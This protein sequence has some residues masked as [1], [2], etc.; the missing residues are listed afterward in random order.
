MEE[1]ALNEMYLLITRVVI[2]VN[3]FG[4]MAMH[5]PYKSDDILC[6]NTF[7]VKKVW[8]SK[9]EPCLEVKAWTYW[10]QQDLWLDLQKEVLYV[11][12]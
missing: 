9:V 12:L 8:Q 11:Q 4:P 1:S 2:G 5:E 6:K 10:W 7:S 3:N